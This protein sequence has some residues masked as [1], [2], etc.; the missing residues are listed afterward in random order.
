V[1]QYFPVESLP[2]ADGKEYESGNEE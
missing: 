2:N 1:A